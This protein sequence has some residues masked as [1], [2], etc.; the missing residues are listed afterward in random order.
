[1]STLAQ[2][3]PQ[4]VHFAIAL[5]LIGVLFRLVSLTGRLRFTNHAAAALILFGTAATLVSVKSGDAAHGPVERI[6]GVRPMVVEHEEAA[7][8]VERIL[9]GVLIIEAIGLGLSRSPR[10]ARFTRGAHLLSAAVGIWGGIAMA[11]TAQLGG[12]IVY[13]YAGGPGL[14]SGTDTDIG[15]LLLAGLHAQAQVDRSAQRIEDAVRLVDE[16]ARR[17]PND[18][19]VQ[20]LRA[21]SLL[22][23][24]T[25]PAEAMA[26]L[27]AIGVRA[28]DARLAPRRALLAA[29]IWVAMQQPEAAKAE[30]DQ[31]IDAFPQNTRLKARRDSLP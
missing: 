7:E 9:L 28:D 8:W 29:E 20:F 23:D 19:S 11:R 6:P 17:F 26:A 22:R 18:T 3:H 10:T 4:V 12:Q 13:E 30:L 1:M 25:Q 14:R 16:M 27:N 2:L 24:R 31:A 15:R 21:E 5:T